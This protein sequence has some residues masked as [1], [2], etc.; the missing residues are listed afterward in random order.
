[1]MDFQFFGTI[2]E[3]KDM[4]KELY[5][6]ANLIEDEIEIEEENNFEFYVGEILEITKPKME[7]VDEVIELMAEFQ[8]ETIE[9]TI[10]EIN[11]ILKECGWNNKFYKCPD[12]GEIHLSE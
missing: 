10:F 11:K 1:M 4:I 7:N 2:E 3:L 8:D 12:C 6:E 5:D 9:D